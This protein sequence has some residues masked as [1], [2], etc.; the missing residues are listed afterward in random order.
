MQIP[1]FGRLAPSDSV[2]LIGCGGGFDVVS[3]IPLVVWLLSQGKKVTL[4]NVSFAEIDR[5]CN[6]RVGPLGWVVDG[7]CGETG[8]FPERAL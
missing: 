4:G 6:E 3:G 5:L 7:E 8:Y 2:L 1:F